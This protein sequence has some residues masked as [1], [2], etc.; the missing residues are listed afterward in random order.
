VAETQQVIIEFVTN[1]EQLDSAIDKL[2]KT[3]AIDSKLASAFKQTT[4]EINKQTT[5]I[6]KAATATAPLKKN[7]EDIDKATKSFTQ[8][9]MTGFNEGVIETLKEAGVTAEQFSAALKSSQTEVLEPAESLRQRLK[10]LTQQIAEMKLA[11]DDGT[12]AFQKL[13]IEAGNIKDAMADAGAEIKNAGSDTQTFDN[14]LGSAQAVAGGFA[15]A[16]GAVAL[17]GEENKDL[18]KTM[19]KVNAAI[20]ITQGLQSISSALEKEGALSLLAANIQLK[21]K[22]AQKVIENGL[23]SQ[24]IVVRS[25][26]IVAQKALNAAMAANPIGIVV[27]AL[28]GLIG[29]LATYGRSAAAARQQTSDLNVALGQ[30]AKNFEERAEA[31]KQL[32]ESSINSLEN[33][34][35]V[36]S[37]I[38]QVRVENEKQLADARKQRIAELRDLEAKTADAELEKRQELQAE[39][40]KLE[41]QS[42]TDQLNIN[43]LE[44]KQQKILNEERLKSTVAGLEA[45]LTAA[46]EGSQNQLNLQRRL[47]AARTS[48]ELN[49]DGL[50]ENERRSIIE[51]GSKEREEVDAAAQKR[52]IDL[53]LKGIETQLVNVK[54]GSQEELDLKKQAVKLQMDAEL[55]NTKLSE[56]EKKAIKEKGFEDQLKLQRDFNERVR[57]EAIEAQV[58][59][60]DAQISQIKTNDEDRLILQIANIELAAAAEVDAAKGNSAKI[61]EINAKRD[62]DILAVKKKFIDDAAQYEI[63]IL[64]ADNGPV[65]RALQ[66]LIADEKKGLQARKSAIKQLAEFQI[67]NIDIQLAALEVEKNKKLISEKDYILKYKQLQ[68]KKKEIT[69]ESEKATTDLIKAETKERIDVAINVA[70]QL[71]DLFQ[72]ISDTES[73]KENDRLEGERQRVAE[74]LEAGAITEKEAAARNKRLDAEEK[75]IKAQ[76]AQ[77]EKNLAVFRAFLAI[78]QAFLQGLAQGGPIVGAIYAA[79]AAAQAVVIASRPLPRFGHGK[80]SGYEGPAEIGETGPELYTQNGQMLLAD[81][82]QL[83]WLAAK[84]KVYNPTET[85]EMLM[86]KVDKQLMQW[87]PTPQS[88][89]EID[90]DQLAKAVGKNINIPGFNIDEEGFKIWEQKGQHRKNYMDKRYSSK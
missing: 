34:G 82:K 28:A 83:V 55:T 15:V 64:T 66:R 60:N 11:G 12:E 87:Q 21:V 45:Q 63:D 58:S 77:R 1:D 27:V 67:S 61:K 54:E 43:N 33:E 85:K 78:P 57:R 71:L 86:P 65:T 39:L 17:F 3:G 84:D 2:E 50:L 35:A 37:K 36:A 70:N 42:L 53:Q 38:A 47:I 14:L 76:Q 5:E 41:D 31:I 75:K 4:A 40:R 20:A 68:D 62:A 81:K 89:L 22:N 8:D 44:V 10:S 51:K 6:K 30:G 18:E 9:F 19:L 72:S 73:Q 7:L 74:L 49:A 79:I 25:A 16:Q 90:Y 88:R 32:G 69:E 48:L 56:E 52:R 13:V 46:E 29:L 80:K 24:S 59:L 26:A 23:E